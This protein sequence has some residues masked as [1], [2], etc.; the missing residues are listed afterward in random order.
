MFEQLTLWDS[1]NCTSLQGLA[2]GRSPC[3][4]PDGPMIGHAGRGVVLAS[5]FP[6]L[7]SAREA[8]MIGTFGPPS[9]ASLKLADLLSYSENRSPA[10][11]CSEVLGRNLAERLK[12]RL[13]RFGSMEYSLTWKEHLTPARRLIFRLRASGH[14][15]SG[16]GVIGWRSPAAQNGEGGPISF[17]ASHKRSIQTLQSQAALAGWATPDAQAM[18][19]G[20]GLETW[21]ARQILNKE[22]YRNG[23]G[24]GM[25]LA[26]QAQTALAQWPT[27]SSRDWKDTPGM[28]TIGTN[29]DG[30]ERTRLDQLPRVASLAVWP[31]PKGNDSTGASET[32]T[33]QG[34]ADLKTASGLVPPPAQAGQDLAGWPTPMAGSP[35][36]EEYNEAGNNDSSRKTVELC[37]WATPHTPRE[38]GSDNSTSTYLDRQ[39]LGKISTPSPAGTVKR[40]ALNAAHSRWLMGFPETWCIAAILAYRSIPKRRRKVASCGSRA[41]ETPSIP[42]SP[43][44]SSKRPKKPSR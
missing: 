25:P 5:H 21:D 35:S 30:S 17:E 20:E 36:T 27:P 14:R 37:G 38:H 40:G 29:P 24:A 41:T 6:A 2:A 1:L 8:R 43:P 31:T 44:N 3:A 26:I 42:I 9:L 7:E 12:D 18:N 34:G 32:K 39:L 15:T 28:A 10:P 22:K 4:S 16:K 13:S 33:R 19:D 11:M 23:N